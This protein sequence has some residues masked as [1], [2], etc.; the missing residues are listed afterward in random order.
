[1]SAFLSPTYVDAAGKR[2]QEDSQ[3]KVQS[4]GRHTFF[5]HV[6]STYI[7]D[8]ILALFSRYVQCMQLLTCVTSIA[9]DGI[10]D[11]KHCW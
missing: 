4:L 10:C 3:V 11:H 1:M 5:L 7:I 9:G 2:G 6:P 8:V